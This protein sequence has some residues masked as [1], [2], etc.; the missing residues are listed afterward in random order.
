MWKPQHHW[1]ESLIDSSSTVAPHPRERMIE[2]HQSMGGSSVGHW[3]GRAPST[4]QKSESLQP[5][6]HGNY[7]DDLP[8]RCTSPHGVSTPTPLA[9]FSWRVWSI[10]QHFC[11][12]HAQSTLEECDARRLERLQD[13]P[14]TSR[15]TRVTPVV[16]RSNS[17]LYHCVWCCWSVSHF[18]RAWS[19]RQPDIG[20]K[21]FYYATF[22]YANNV[23]RR[24]GE[25]V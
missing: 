25:C 15:R 18:E 12:E 24:C 9:Y 11:P 13:E 23:C 6:Q 1:L 3:G 7:N 5:Q 2:A 4:V 21:S 8:G 16:D 19:A 22:Y 20:S 10:A 17:S 14:D